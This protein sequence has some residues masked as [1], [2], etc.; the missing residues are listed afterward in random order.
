[1]AAYYCSAIARFVAT[2]VPPPDTHPADYPGTIP[3]DP[4]RDA[5]AQE[6][7]NAIARSMKR[8][9]GSPRLGVELWSFPDLEGP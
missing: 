8:F 1:M 4:V 6:A 7:A 9:F 2:P 3:Y 5:L